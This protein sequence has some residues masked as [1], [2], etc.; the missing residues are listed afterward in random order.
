MDLEDQFELGHLF[1]SQRICRSCNQTKDLLDEYYKIRKTS[2]P[3]AYS[4]ECKV[5][6]IDRITKK[7]VTIRDHTRWEYP[8][9]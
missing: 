5:C 1:L 2:G 8:D 9:W 4:Y 6:T 7:R 3:S